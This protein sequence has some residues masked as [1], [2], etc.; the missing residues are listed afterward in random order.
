M[1]SRHL[2]IEG[3]SISPLNNTSGSLSEKLLSADL[4]LGAPALGS[5]LCSSTLYTS[6]KCMMVMEGARGPLWTPT[7]GVMLLV[8]DAASADTMLRGV[9]SR[10]LLATEVFS[11]NI[12]YMDSTNMSKHTHRHE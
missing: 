9:W 10:L 6:L 3:A 12:N 11:C 1:G 5:V 4:N 7:A 2:L 8:P